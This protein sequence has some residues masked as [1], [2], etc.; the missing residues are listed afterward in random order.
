MGFCQ[1]HIFL[2]STVNGRKQRKKRSLSLVLFS[3]A[4]LFFLYWPYTLRAQ[5]KIEKGQGKKQGETIVVPLENSGDSGDSIEIENADEADYIRGEEG[6]DAS[7]KLRGR[8]RVRL[9]KS[10]FTADT[11]IIDTKNEEVYAEGNLILKSEDGSSIKAER[12]IYSRRLSQGILYNA[13][14][15]KKPLYFIGKNVHLLAKQRLA[16]SHARFTTN[17]ARPPHYHFSVKRLGFYENTFFAVGVT[18]YIGGVP[19]LPLPFL[20]SSP[21]GTGIIT[22]L[23]SGKSQGNFIQNTY[24]FGVPDRKELG[25]KSIAPTSY[26]FIFDAYQNT[27]ENYAIEIAREGRDLDYQINLGYANFKRYNLVDGQ[28]TNQVERC[29][30]GSHFGTPRTCNLGEESFSWFKRHFLIH[31]KTNDLSKNYVRDI[32]ILYENYGHFLYDYEFGRRFRPENTLSALNRGLR[33]DEGNLHPNTNLELNY[34]EEWD[35][36]YFK[37]KAKQRK[38]WRSRE[39]FQDS[40]Y[41]PAQDIMPR[42][43]L[44]KRF[45]LGKLPAFGTP[46]D[47]NHKLSFEKQRDYTQGEIFS[48]RSTNEYITDLN[49]SLP[50]LSF[51]YWDI[52]AGYGTRQS[53]Y[54][55]DKGDLQAA[56]KLSLELEGK[57]DTYQYLFSENTY[58]LALTETTDLLLDIIH[59]YKKPFSEERNETPRIGSSDSSYNQI[60]NEAE[61][62]LHYFPLP[63]ISFTFNAVYDY[64]QFP[65]EVPQGSRWNTPV[66]RS[67][68]LLNWLNL[69]EEERNNLL[70]RNK[71]HFFNTH[72]TNDYVYNP[73]FKTGQSNTFSVTLEA[74]GYDLSF[75][76]RLRYL[77]TGFQWYHSY[78]DASLDHL[79]YILKMDIQ[80]GNWSYLETVMESRASQPERY[81]SSSVDR[82]NRP[83]GI[84]FWEDL[85]N[86]LGLGGSNKRRDALFS[87]LYFSTAFIFDLGD[88]EFRLGYEQ[89]QR[90]IPETSNN[91]N[92]LIY[93]EQRIYFGLNL[94]RFDVGGYGK[95]PSSFLLDRKRSPTPE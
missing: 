28:V 48:E 2:S 30:G 55:L 50:L 93:Y 65:Q 38:V 61:L 70:S 23:G 42:L 45:S 58:S 71:V 40:N 5:K 59:R 53:L 63:N 14:G 19:L 49:F 21:W 92:P 27:G 1:L 22:Q 57:R 87:I 88:W 3:L 46:I 77:E 85:G 69:F 36:F 51:F 75:F 66:F 68:I 13:A 29:Q 82:E 9:S 64:R 62:D 56:E 15:Y 86:S 12:M 73:I 60:I 89:E 41:E 76:R 33:L 35:T 72:I 39:N 11:V 37:L 7:L 4:L 83:D 90:Y 8:I 6:S 32:H 52:K 84:D 20:Y 26:T 47:W 18:Y 54:N 10:Q 17:A 25:Q 16:L 81:K 80:L 95:R 79:R 74:G 78:F 94:I 24:Q 31:S 34:I 67:D 43:D 44:G 91:V